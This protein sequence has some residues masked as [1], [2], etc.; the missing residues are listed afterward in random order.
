[1]LNKKLVGLESS[2][3]WTLKVRN[4]V[5]GKRALTTSIFI[6]ILNVIKSETEAAVNDEIQEKIKDEKVQ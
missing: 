6:F 4:H 5:L 2:L 1:M 3:G